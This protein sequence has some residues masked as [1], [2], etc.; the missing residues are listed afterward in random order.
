M[1]KILFKYYALVPLLMLCAFYI[2]KALAFPIHDFANY[3]YGGYFLREN[4][5]TTN[6][7]F[8]YLFNKEIVA[9]GNPPLFAGFAPNTP[10]L[11]MLLYPFTYI[12][13]ASAKLLFNIISA[14]LFI[15]SIYSLTKFYKINWVYLTLIPFAFFVP[16]RNELLF[17]QVYLLL[18]TL[19]T[20][21][22]LA[23]EKNQQFKAAMFLCCAI[24][25]K[26]FPILL[27]MIFPFKKQF[28][29]MFY[30]AGIGVLFFCI[31]LMWVDFNF[32]RF[33]V[34]D[35][36]LK[37]SNGEIAS[38]FVDNYQ[39]IFMFLKRVFVYDSVEN[40]HPF[41]HASGFF[42]IAL[43]AFKIGGLS[44][45]YFITKN[46]KNNLEVFGFWILSMILLSPY[47][48]TYTFILML[49]PFFALLKSEISTVKKNIFC[50]M[51]ILVNNLPLALFM[52]KTFPISYLRLFFL[53]AFFIFFVACFFQKSSL[54]KAVFIGFIVF[55]IGTF[56]AEQKPQN[57]T[58]LFITESPLLIYDYKI[59]NNQL[60]YFYWNEKGENEASIPFECLSA[61]ALSL[62]ENQIVFKNN[63][64]TSDSDHKYKPMLINNTTV[65]YL[66]DYDRGIGFYTLR[67]IELH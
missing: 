28:K 17:G 30:T 40:S 58:S 1:K 55:G 7:Y 5:F 42:S 65:I 11:A 31:S 13:L 56:F 4:T 47:G 15:N 43:L 12:S 35:V 36:L 29:P 19:L 21:F 25:L 6:T 46:S 50:G 41:F 22:W 39:S 26:V 57:S 9:L 3:Y 51:L 20:E 16:I 34:N 64:L 33:Y 37:A 24:F 14:V 63:I 67:K 48:S 62:R 52:E 54:L 8:P 2:Y 49:F 61:K 32:W 59:E 45:A 53:I 44:L 10:F 23:N 60:T 38:S 66:S 18:F 27:I